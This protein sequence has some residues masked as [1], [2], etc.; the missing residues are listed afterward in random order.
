[1]HATDF[2]NIVYEKDDQS[3]IVLVTINR[4]EINNALT[5]LVLLELYRAADRSGL[6]GT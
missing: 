4:P 5:I 3:G 6:A 1:M 2:N